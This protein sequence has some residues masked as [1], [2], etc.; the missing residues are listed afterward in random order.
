MQKELLE[1]AKKYR[2]ARAAR[3]QAELKCHQ[4]QQVVFL[5]LR[6]HHVGYDSDLRIEVGQQRLHER[7][8][9]GSDVAGNHDETIALPETVL[10]ERKRA[11]VFLTRIEE[12][13][14]G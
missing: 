1:I 13:C 7:R 11:L 3:P 10:Q 14:I 2:F 4:R 6:R 12:A 5:Q 8:L 9:A